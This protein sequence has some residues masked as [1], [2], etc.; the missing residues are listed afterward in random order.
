M[1]FADLPLEPTMFPLDFS[2]DANDI[3]FPIDGLR[4]LGVM[5][6]IDPPRGEVSTSF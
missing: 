4:F 5:G 2:F 3:N 6:I 1:A